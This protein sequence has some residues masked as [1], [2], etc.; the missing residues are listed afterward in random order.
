[1][2]IEAARLQV[3]VETDAR[4]ALS[5]LRNVE[6]QAKSTADALDGMGASGGGLSGVV[7]GAKD[8]L[9]ML[10]GIGMAAGLAGKAIS[11]L[12]APVQDVIGRGFAYRSMWEQ[13]EIGFTTMLGSAEA[14]RKQLGDL[15]SFAEKTPFE[16]PDTITGARRLMALGFAAKDVI[17]MLT[18]VG[19]ATA[20]LGGNAD[21]L[22]RLTMAL[23]QMRTKG[24]V[25]AEEMMQLA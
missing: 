12:S 6:K 21:M 14:A 17:P 24:K 13:A 16:F 8:L 4:A 15:A 20:A 25:S 11:A 2:T 5:T 19:D 10:P 18:A 9:T 22:D 3:R 7:G 23:G 1:M